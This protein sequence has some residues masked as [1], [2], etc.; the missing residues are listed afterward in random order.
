MKKFLLNQNKVGDKWVTFIVELKEGDDPKKIKED[1]NLQGQVMVVDVP[2]EET[3]ET[4]KQK[5]EAF[6]QK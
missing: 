1:A 4:M 6:N 3:L 5:L 2:D